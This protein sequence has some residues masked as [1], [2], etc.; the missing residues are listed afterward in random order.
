MQP[1]VASVDP[2][3]KYRLIARPLQFVWKTNLN[4]RIVMSASV[5]CS[6]TGSHNRTSTEHSCLSVLFDSKIVRIIG[7]INI[8][9]GTIF[10]VEIETV[11]K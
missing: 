11:I 10:L 6:S 2:S 7:I 1:T 5:L 9:F 4:G 3:E 8:I